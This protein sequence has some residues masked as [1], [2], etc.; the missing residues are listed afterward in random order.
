[1]WWKEFKDS[2]LDRLVDL[3]MKSNPA[4]EE[5][6]DRLRAAQAAIDTTEGILYPHVD[7]VGSLRRQRLS[8]N[9]NNTIYNGK[10]ATIANVFPLF[11][12]YNLDLWNRNG[13]IISAVSSSEKGGEARYRQSALML[14]SSVIKTYFAL[15]TARNL[16]ETQAEIVKLTAEK[17]DLLTAA[18]TAGIRPKTPSISVH[19]DLSE[20]KAALATLENRRK[21][22]NFALL[23]LLGKPPGER[24]DPASTNIPER[25]G[26]PERIDLDL[27]SKRPDVQAALW[28]VKRASSLE[29][30]ARDAFYPNINLFALAGFNS[31]GISDLLGPGGATYAYGPAVDLPIFEGG[32]LTGRLHEKE[33]AFDEAVHAYNRILLAAV[34]Q[35]ADALSAMQYGKERLDERNASL[36]LRRLE[37]G[38]A[39]SGFRAGVSGKLPLLEAE[40]RMD[41]E[42]MAIME[43]RLNWL[44]SITDAATALGGGFGRWP[45]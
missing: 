40:I 17:A 6:K 2:S 35:I 12:N 44:N 3:A 36:E 33:A 38:I 5:A 42:K 23:E 28:N 34:R 30:V 13:E 14:S 8:R 26:L 11:V 37:A 45:S 19:A 41:R 27:V 25:F 16:V 22:L 32:A 31:I 21:S 9:G 10:T 43:D 4:L 39:C 15:N 1:M 20:S 24:V 29:K 18:Y 7:S